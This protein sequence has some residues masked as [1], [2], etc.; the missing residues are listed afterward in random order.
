MR[1][2]D[3][4]AQTSKDLGIDFLVLSNFSNIFFF[5]ENKISRATAMYPMLTRKLAFG[6]SSMIKAQKR[7][8]KISGAVALLSVNVYNKRRYTTCLQV[9]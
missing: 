2:K 3:N 5:S 9:V 7:H 4:M 8:F 1:Q 6:D